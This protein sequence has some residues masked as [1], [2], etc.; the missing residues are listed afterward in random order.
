MHDLS[1]MENILHEI[2]KT[3]K[4]DLSL[5]ILL[6]IFRI[7]HNLCACLLFMTGYPIYDA[8]CVALQTVRKWL[9]KNA[10]QVSLSICYRSKLNSGQ[11]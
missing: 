11:N 4:T 8:S 1:K 5:A 9:E 6:T 2:S 3:L 7:R 10:D